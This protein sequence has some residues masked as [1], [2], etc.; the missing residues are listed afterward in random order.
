M[1]Y[2]VSQRG[3]RALSR[4]VRGSSS[5]GTATFS[6]ASVSPDDF[7]PPY[8]VRWSAAAN[9][10][11]GAWVIWLGDRSRVLYHNGVSQQP[12]GVVPES[13]LPTGWFRIRTVSASS[14]AVWLNVRAD[15]STGAFGDAILSQAP[16]SATTGY[17][18]ASY[19]VAT[20][21]HDST[22]GAV[23]VRQFV[24]SAVVLTSYG[25]GGSGSGYTGA[26][27]VPYAFDG[28]RSDGKLYALTRTWT[29][30]DGLLQSVTTGPDV[31][32]ADTVEHSGI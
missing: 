12:D 15:S 25:G 29:F 10:K 31:V 7:A 17:D 5:A 24:D 28:P 4:L 19:C 22:T 18:V 6:P 21:T 30:A 11:D 32:V 16:G 13:A 8:T 9:S 1:A 23:R 3:V 27:N 26:Q 14:T 2:V 20:M